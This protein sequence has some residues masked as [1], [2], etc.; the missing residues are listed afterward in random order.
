MR[1]PLVEFMSGTLFVGVGKSFPAAALPLDFIFNLLFVSL[2]LLVFFT[3][4][5]QQVIPDAASVSGI[6]LG[7]F[8]N[9]FKSISYQSQGPMTPFLSA[10]YGMLLGYLLLLLIAR[11]GERMFKKE[12]MGEGDL[13]LAALLGAYLGWE[14]ALLSVFLAYLLAGAAVLVF[15]LFKRVKMGDYVPFGPALAAGGVLSLFFGPQILALYLGVF[16]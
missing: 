12:V 3:D 5:E 11:L 14:G 6:F 13:Y 9:Y 1:Y 15:M 8:H 16:K 4:L 2:M 10:V 7:L